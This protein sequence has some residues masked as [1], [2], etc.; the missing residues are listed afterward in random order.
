MTG[1]V[2]IIHGAR[3]IG[4]ASGQSPDWPIKLKRYLEERGFAEVRPFYWSGEVLDGFSPALAQHYATSLHVLSTDY[5]RH[6]VHIIGKSLGG[7][8]AEFALYRLSEQQ[9]VSLNVRRLLR[10]GC[11]DKRPPIH[12][13]FVHTVANIVSSADV[14]ARVYTPPLTLLLRCLRRRPWQLSDRWTEIKLTGI[15][16]RDF[17]HPVPIRHPPFTGTNLYD[18]YA[19]LMRMSGTHVDKSGR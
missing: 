11:P 13:P 16:H 7:I 1:V 15:G 17:N 6:D 9:N 8:V 3:R 19:D 5:P 14:L 4:R 18:L 10:L 2:S 12:L